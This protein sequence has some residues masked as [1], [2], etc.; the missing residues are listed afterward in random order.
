MDEKKK[1][2]EQ[3]ESILEIAYEQEQEV[4]DMLKEVKSQLHKA[5]FPRASGPYKAVKDYGQWPKFLKEQ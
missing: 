1:T 4:L 2:S 3:V 5:N